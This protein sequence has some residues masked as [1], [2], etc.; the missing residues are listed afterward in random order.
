MLSIGGNDSGFSTIGLTCGGPGD[1]TDIEH[2]WLGNLRDVADEVGRAYQ[3]VRGA[4]PDT[5]VL[6]VP[7]VLPM[8]DGGDCGEIWL[9]L[10]E[11]AFV[12]RFARALNSHLKE[13]AQ[14]ARFHFLDAMQDAMAARP[15]GEGRQ[16]RG[17]L[18]L[19]DVPIGDAG[20][21][22]VGLRSV[23]GGLPRQA[24]NPRHWVH[25]SLHPN[26]RGHNRMGQVVREW[27]DD[28]PD[29][30]A[31]AAPEP[32]GIPLPQGRLPDPGCSVFDEGET[33]CKERALEW[34]KGEALEM[35]PMAALAGAAVAMGAALTGVGA[36]AETRRRKD[37]RRAARANSEEGGTARAGS[38][39]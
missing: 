29:P 19:C 1:C 22:F 33:G 28:H 11:R 26:E 34:G 16:A 5:P 32:D 9:T 10:R 25:N 37:C 38:T 39:T 23:S 4:F 7:Y 3:A 2:Y 18:R 6:A 30:A 31:Q 21:N 27:L 17:S 15:A 36:V 35:A 8:S 14:D 20:V 12:D 24:L 13:Q